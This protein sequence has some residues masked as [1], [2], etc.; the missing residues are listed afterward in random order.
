MKWKNFFGWIAT[1]LV[2]SF[3]CL[4]AF[5]GS[6]ENFHEGW[7]YESFWK[8]VALMF[9]QYLPFGLSFTIVGAISVLWPRVG[10]SIFLAGAVGAY[11]LFQTG[12]GLVIFAIPLLAAA[13]CFWFGNPPPRKWALILVVGLPLLTMVGFSV[14]PAIRVSGRIDDG[15]YH[16]RVIE[17]NGVK[18]M[19]APEGPGWTTTAE[20]LKNASWYG[21]TLACQFL[22]KEGT[23][24]ADTPQN[25]W[26]LPTVDEAVRSSVRH[27]TNAG[28]IWDSASKSPSYNT[29]PDKESP[30]WKVHS[31][32]IYWWTSTE[33]NDTTAYRIVYNGGVQRLYKKI[34]MGDLGFRAVREVR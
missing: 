20:D 26:R 24:L 16:A 23:A 15:N 1:I 31:P 32:V 21:A 33:P 7:F 8:N 9:I 10:A 29:M 2:A 34:R 6:I 22:N 3:A 25:I 17:G 19:W 13:I 14:E 4:W 12:A 28:G 27:G 5:W 30:L 18:L 11:F